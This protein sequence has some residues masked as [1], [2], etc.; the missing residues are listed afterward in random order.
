[1]IRRAT[2]IAAT[3]LVGVLAS[4]SAWAA[5]P[6]GSSDDNLVSYPAPKT[7][8]RGG[9]AMGVTTGFALVD[10]SGYPNEAVAIGDPNRL[11][12]TGPALGSSFE[13]WLGGAIRDWLTAGVGLAATSALTGDYTAANAA[14]ALHLEA[15]PLFYRGGEWRNLGLAVDGG[16]G[17]ASMYDRDDTQLENILAYG[18]SSSFL[19]GTAFWEPFEFWQF[20]TGPSLTAGASFSQTLTATQL[21][22]GWRFVFYGDQPRHTATKTAGSA[23]VAF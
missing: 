20:S 8:R 7:E 13:I 4:S 14:F 16:I 12:A 6:G 10:F 11:A 3:S 9:F 1:M 21:M 5:A 17:T 19:T 22:L 2:K 15:F 18:G 23:T